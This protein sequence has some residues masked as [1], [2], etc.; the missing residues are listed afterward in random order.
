MLRAMLLSIIDL[1]RTQLRNDVVK[2]KVHARLVKY[3]GYERN[4]VSKQ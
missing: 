1:K 3:N 2:K 4:I